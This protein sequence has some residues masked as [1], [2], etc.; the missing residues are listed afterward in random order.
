MTLA[1]K[2][3]GCGVRGAGCVCPILYPSGRPEPMIESPTTGWRCPVCRSGVS[4]NVKKCPC[5]QKG[6]E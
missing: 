5:Q 2:C 6:P 3:P 1:D 4:P